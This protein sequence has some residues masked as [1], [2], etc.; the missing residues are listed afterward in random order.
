M[1]SA[2]GLL[3]TLLVFSPGVL[4]K[5]MQIRVGGFYAES[6][7]SIDVTDPLLGNDFKLDFETDLE[8]AESQFLPFFEFE[9]ASGNRHNLYLDWKRLHRSGE[10][11][12]VSKPFQINIDDTVYEVQAGARLRT[13]LDIDILRLGYG[14]DFLESDQYTLGVT[15]GLHTMFI[16]TVLEGR[17]GACN[18]GDLSAGQCVQ[19]PIPQLVEHDVTAPL[20]DIGLIGRYQLWQGFEFSAHAQYFYI[21]LDDLQGGLTDIR[22]GISS[23]IG[24]NWQISMSYN[25]YEVSVDIRDSRYNIKIADYNIHY[26][27]TGPKLA[28]SYRF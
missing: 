1:K 21:E 3:I 15:L 28:V 14:Y 7:S 17:I 8:L 4:A 16:S 13:D 26:S 11:Q 19:T 9:Y 18:A 24:D 10:T 23:N 25:Y 12:A 27:F 6:D 22:A 20:P 5:D 2:K